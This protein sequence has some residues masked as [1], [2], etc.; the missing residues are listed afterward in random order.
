MSLCRTFDFTVTFESYVSPSP[1]SL[2]QVYRARNAQVPRL[3]SIGGFYSIRFQCHVSEAEY[4]RYTAGECFRFCFIHFMRHSQSSCSDFVVSLAYCHATIFHEYCHCGPQPFIIRLGSVF[5]FI[6]SL[7]TD[8]HK[9]QIIQILLV[10]RRG[11][12]LM[13]AFYLSLFRTFTL[14]LTAPQIRTFV[15]GRPFVSPFFFMALLIRY[16]LETLS[17]VSLNLPRF[18]D[19]DYAAENAG[20]ISRL[21]AFWAFPLIWKERQG[22]LHVGDLPKLHPDMES[23]SLFLRF[24]HA[25]RIERCGSSL[26]FSAGISLT[27]HR[28]KLEHSIPGSPPSIIRVLIR[29]FY[30]TLLGVII[31]GTIR[32][33]AQ[34]IQPVLAYAAIRFVESYSASDPPPQPAQYGWA[35]AGAFALV[36]STLAAATCVYF[37]YTYQTAAVI[38]G[39]LCEAIYR[40]SLTLSAADT[41]SDNC[42][43]PLSLMRCVLVCL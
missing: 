18:S 43:N 8:S 11:R 10:H 13:S 37:D 21:F 30:P 32:A 1:I 12:M 29:A 35:L 39:A 23:T 16:A 28:K 27:C 33:L 20:F 19:N 42:G 15:I 14:V 17:L 4:P 40:K 34:G 9:A 2:V 22:K 36:L 25:W 24:D 41:A 38:R 31:P 6:R 26:P 7:L 5:M 3:H